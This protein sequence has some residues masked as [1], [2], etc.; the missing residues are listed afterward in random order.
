MHHLGAVLGDAALLVL[1]AH[2]EARDVLQ[3]HQRDVAL[4]AQLD[5]MRGLQRRLGEQ[6]PEVGDDAHWVIKKS[7]T[8]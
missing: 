7:G 8:R 5:E 3:K 4:A 1:L 2:H 6:H